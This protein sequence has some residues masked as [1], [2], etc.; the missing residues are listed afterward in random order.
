MVITLVIS[1]LEKIVVGS[2][3][4]SF[5]HDFAY[6]F[7]DQYYKLGAPEAP[8]ES[9]AKRRRPPVRE[10]LRAGESVETRSRN[11]RNDKSRS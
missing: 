1:A 6:S 5:Q 3:W 4:K 10:A 9:G 8:P 2:V 7:L 11:A